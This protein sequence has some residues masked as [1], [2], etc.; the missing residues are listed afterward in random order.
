MLPAHQVSNQVSNILRRDEARQP[1][2]ADFHQFLFA[3]M[4]NRPMVGCNLATGYFS[5]FL[6]DF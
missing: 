6:A 1:I 4:R 5:E 2:F 3:H